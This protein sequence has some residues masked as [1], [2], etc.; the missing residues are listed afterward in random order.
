MLAKTLQTPPTAQLTLIEASLTL[1]GVFWQCSWQCHAVKAFLSFLQGVPARNTEL[2]G[3]SWVASGK[4]R[5]LSVLHMTI[6]YQNEF[7]DG[8]KT[9]VPGWNTLQKWK[10]S[11][12]SMTLPATLPKYT[13]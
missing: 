10:K 2:Q 8:T 3:I 7:E 1:T 4:D 9:S 12:H 13:S 11:F 6:C 5:C